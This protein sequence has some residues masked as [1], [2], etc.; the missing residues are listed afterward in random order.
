MIEGSS[1][2]EE[3]SQMDRFIPAKFVYLVRYFVMSFVGAYPV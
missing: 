1:D 3:E 2:N